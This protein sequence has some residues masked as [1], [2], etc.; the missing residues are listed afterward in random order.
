MIINILQH[1][2]ILRSAQDDR[3]FIFKGGG[4]QGRFA[5]IF[6]S[7]E[8]SDTKRP[9]FPPKNLTQ[10]KNVI[11]SGAFSFTPIFYL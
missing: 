4:K 3:F 5:L 10:Q 1:D 7:Y 8:N 9:C 11:L 2:E 6:L